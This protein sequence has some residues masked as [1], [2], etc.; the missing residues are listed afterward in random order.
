MHRSF[1]SV[2]IAA[3]LLLAYVQQRISLVSL[4]YQVE[5]L[6]LTKDDLLEAIAE[7]ER[8]NRRFG[9]VAAQRS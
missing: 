4:G 8:R 7:Y 1:L 5:R 9:R 2:G 3:C 6:K